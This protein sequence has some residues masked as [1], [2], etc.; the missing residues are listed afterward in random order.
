MPHFQY[1]ASDQRGR[2]V[3]GELEAEGR[4]DGLAKIRGLGYLPLEITEGAQFSGATGQYRGKR[5][6]QRDLLIFTQQLASLLDAGLQ[7]DRGLAVIVDLAP[8]EAAKELVSE[9]R[10]DVQGGVALSDAMQ[11]YP[12]I[13]SRFYV[14]MV[15]AGEAAG[16][17]DGVLRRLAEFL[18]RESELRGYLRA[19]MIYPVIMAVLSLGA[20]VMLLTMVVPRFV[21]IFADLGQALP[22]PTLILVQTSDWVV[23]FWW[24]IAVSIAGVWTAAKWYVKTGNGRLRVDQWALKLPLL[25]ELIQKTAVSRFARTLATLLSSGVTL[26]KA[27]RILRDATGNEA[28]G[29]A[30][31]N[32]VQKVEAGGGLARRLEAEAVF[33]A[34]AVHMIG[35]GEET[36]NLEGMLEKVA[37]TFDTE[38]RNSIKAALSV[39]EPAL[40]LSMALVVGFIVAAMLL[41]IVS[42]NSLSF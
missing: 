14:S 34:M 28:L 19:S 33:P 11:K 27:L 29:R 6:T 37:N 8:N 24:V 9:L 1:S 23:R 13:F 38:L 18:E 3:K 26:P 22:L 4:E 31:E 12:R 40:I 32:T 2:V 25:G 41:P 39:L 7:V 10:R 17:L 35:V 42:I 15:R 5:V 30:L 21:E 36:G 16:A 20:V